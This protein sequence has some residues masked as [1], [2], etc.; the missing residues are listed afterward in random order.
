L[1]TIYL[2]HLIWVQ[3]KI[4]HALEIEKVRA[5]ESERVRKQTAIDFHDELGHRLTRISLLTEIVKRKLGDSHWEVLPLL[6][7]I[8]ENSIQLYDG[9]KDFIW[10]ID[11]QNDSL[12]ELLVRLK[13][14]GDEIFT[15]TNI[16]FLVKG[17]STELEH[18]SLSTDMKRHLTL[19]FKEGMNNSLKHSGG[20][21]VSLESKIIGDEI[22]IALEDDG[23]GF[24]ISEDNSGNGLK[25]MIKRAERINGQLQINTE[26]GKGTRISFRGKVKTK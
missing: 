23:A 9:T 24:K 15:D 19:I 6:R 21:K 25:N 11:P 10:A 20:R 22:E 12:Y 5:E 3:R 1:I 18:T 4:R 13:D 7:K 16:D 14:F 8:S 26:P 17:I 2:V